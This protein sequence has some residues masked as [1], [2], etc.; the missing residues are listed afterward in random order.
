MEV[1]RTDP[2]REEK[3]ETRDVVR[4]KNGKNGSGVGLLYEP[5]AIPSG[6]RIWWPLHALWPQSN[7]NVVQGTI[8][9]GPQR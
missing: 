4:M 7:D 3:A 1:K 6:D 8:C 9:E 5:R 2:V